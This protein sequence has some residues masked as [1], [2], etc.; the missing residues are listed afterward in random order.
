VEVILEFKKRYWKK[1]KKKPNVHGY[2]GILHPRIKGGKEVPGTRCIRIYV[3]KKVPACQLSRKELIPRALDFGGSIVEIDVVELPRMRYLDEAE[4]RTTP[5]DHQKRYRPVQAGTSCMH[6]NG[7]ACTL[8][9]YFWRGNKLYIALNN[10]CYPGHV[11]VLTREGFKRWDQITGNEE[12]ASLSPSGEIEYLRPVKYHKLYYS[13]EMKLVRSNVFEISMTPG[14]QVYFAEAYHHNHKTGLFRLGTIEDVEKRLESGK[15]TTVRF[16]NTAKWKCEDDPRLTVDVVEFLGWYITEGSANVNSCN[17]KIV[18]IRQREN[19]YYDEIYECMKRIESRTWKCKSAIV[20]N[21]PYLH[22]LLKE[23]GLYGLHT[24]EKFIPQ[25]LK[26][27][28]PYKLEILLDTLRKGD[29][30]K[31][32]RFNTSSKQLANDVCEIALKLGIP[33]LIDVEK[34][35][36]NFSNGKERTLYRVRFLKTKDPLVHEIVTYDYDGFVYDVTLPR[37]HTLFVREKGCGIWAGNCGSLENTANIGDEWLQPSPYDGGVYPRDTVAKLSFYVPTRYE[38]FKC[39]V[40]NFLYRIFKVLYH[41]T[42]LRA[43]EPTNHVDISF[44]EPV[45][46]DILSFKIFG[47]E[48]KVAGKGPHII[49]ARVFKSGRTTAVTEGVIVDPSWNGYVYGRRGKAWYEDCVLV[50]GKCAGGDSGSPTVSR[51]PDGLLYHGAL[52]AGSEDFW[53][54]CK[55]ENIEREANVKLATH[56]NTP[57]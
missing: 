12:F 18:S 29:G 19:R 39:P 11:E 30:D 8:S 56:L 5:I 33:T 17:Q 23:L 3:E 50:K 24:K 2:S 25:Q 43:Y 44:G 55:V 7:T 46:Q 42:H 47:I 36:T 51:S 48:G 35:V 4:D 32:N 41:I 26:N 1:I 22:E 37:N 27:L 13:G 14:N 52:F 57:F 21:S 15:T 10:H 38:T 16:K 53:I 9:W 34:G 28:P 20:A 6:K 45:S 40:R 49:G 54:Y 31:Y